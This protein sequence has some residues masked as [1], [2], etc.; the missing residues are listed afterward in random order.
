MPRAALAALLLAAL[1]LPGCALRGGRLAVTEENDV[2]NLGDG[3]QTDRDYTQGGAAA[4]TLS[5][6]DTPA[7]ARDAAAAIPLFRKDAE[8]HLAVLLGQ[9]IYN[10]A[11]IYTPRFLPGDRPYAGWL[12]G[13]LALQGRA[14]DGDEARRRDRLDTLEADLG[15]VGPA[16]LAEPA[17]NFFHHAF[18]IEEARGWD[19]ALGNEPAFQAAGERRWRA[20]RG[21]LGGGLGAEA[22]PLVRARAGTVHLDGAAGALGRVGWNLPRDFGPMTVDGTGL[23][24]DAPRPAPWVYLHGGGEARGVVHDLFLEGGTFRRGHSVTATDLVHDATLGLAA[25]WGAFSASFSQTWRSPEFREDR[26]FHRFST[27]LVAWTWWF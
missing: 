12:Y 25:G 23:A 24:K 13:G 14:L 15:V 18:D 27:I 21:D 10:P 2:F 20:L 22:I 19:H 4:L 17:Q 11:A 5:A 8:V 16:S 26:R 9:E 3:L 6:E 7:W 1:A